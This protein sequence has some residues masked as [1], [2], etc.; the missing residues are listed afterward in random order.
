MQH[1]RTGLRCPSLPRS[2][3]VGCHEFIVRHW[4]VFRAA[5]RPVVWNATVCADPCTRQRQY[6]AF[7][8]E[9]LETFEH[10]PARSMEAKLKL[11]HVERSAAREARDCK[12][13]EG[14][15]G[16]GWAHLHECSWQF[17]DNTCIISMIGAVHARM[18]SNQEQL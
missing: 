3:C 15:T 2:I 14:M 7:P 1:T 4:F 8:L 12:A 18:Y 11:Q 17:F 6:P 13:D 5:R 9:H 10:S 16:T